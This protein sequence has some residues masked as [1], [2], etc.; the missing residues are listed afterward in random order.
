M[1]KSDFVIEIGCSWGVCTAILA[2]QCEKSQ[3]IGIDVSVEALEN[4]KTQNPGIEFLKMDILAEPIKFQNLVK[5][6]F[7]KHE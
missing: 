7:E 3:V 5:E 1:R 4:C 2:N 6:T